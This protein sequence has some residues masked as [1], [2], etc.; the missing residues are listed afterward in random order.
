MTADP[1]FRQTI[2]LVLS[3][4]YLTKGDDRLLHS[5]LFGPPNE[6]AWNRRL[7]I[8]IFYDRPKLLKAT[9]YLRQ[10]GGA[11][12]KE[13]SV[14]DVWKLITN[15]IQENFWYLS[16]DVFFKEFDDP[17]SERVSE[18]AKNDLANAL[19]VSNLFRKNEV[20]VLYPLVPIRVSENFDTK[21]FFL[22]EPLSLDKARLPVGV[23]EKEI[24]AGQFPPLADWTGK[25]WHP[26]SW[27]GIR[28]PTEQLADK[29]KSVILGA[30]ALLPHPRYR[31]MF[32]GRQMIGGRCILNDAATCSFEGAHTPPLMEDIV[33]G[34]S[35][36]RWLELLGAKLNSNDDAIQKEARALECYYRAWPLDPSHRCPLLF[37]ALDA[38][39]GDPERATQALIESIP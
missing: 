32:S 6:P 33:I 38:L 11:Y 19:A 8:E 13:M 17:F 23:P 4:I 3:A 31:Y 37:T 39:F 18:K 30:V 7:G 22:I 34:G 15:F 12:L 29:K 25:K 14:G 21:T 27:L 35:D 1:V 24:L 26:N 9:L 16:N 2:D 20:L 36:C 5:F 10:Q 28:S